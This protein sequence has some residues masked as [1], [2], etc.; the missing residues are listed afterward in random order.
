MQK[1]STNHQKQVII[2]SKACQKQVIIMSEASHNHVKS[3]P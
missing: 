1:T 2:I 3:K